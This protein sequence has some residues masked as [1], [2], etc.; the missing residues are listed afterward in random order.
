[1]S[2]K[3]RAYLFLQP[4]HFNMK[5]V[6]FTVLLGVLLFFCGVCVVRRTSSVAG[7]CRPRS[8]LEAERRQKEKKGASEERA[9][10]G[11][12][13]HH[14]TA[15]CCGPR[16]RA[17]STACHTC[18]C[19]SLLCHSSRPSP[20]PT[21]GAKLWERG[22]SSRRIA[23]EGG[24]KKGS[25][26]SSFC[27]RLPFGTIVGR[28][29]TMHPRHHAAGWAVGHRSVRAGVPAARV[30][31]GGPTFYDGPAPLPFSPTSGSSSVI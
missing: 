30:A 15:A 21:R 25:S 1:M 16:P 14:A 11:S 27:P 5:E 31:N 10:S 4:H 7:P 20:L 28:P 22:G 26:S 6:R 12:N 19:V 2:G 9:A 23:S 3:T 18:E 29:T 13:V 8:R 24:K 17:L